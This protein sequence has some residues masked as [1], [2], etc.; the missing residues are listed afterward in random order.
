MQ[1]VNTWYSNTLVYTKPKL[2]STLTLVSTVYV[3]KYDY[4]VLNCIITQLERH[5]KIKCNPSKNVFKMY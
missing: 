3:V 1:L 4:W 2:N 5:I